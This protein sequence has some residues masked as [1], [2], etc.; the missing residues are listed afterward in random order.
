LKTIRIERI[1]LYYIVVFPVRLSTLSTVK[2]ISM[3]K[4]T[5]KSVS[6][7]QRIKVK[8]DARTTIMISRMSS[9]KIWK[10]RF[11]E[12]KIIA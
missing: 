5:Q 1:V 4:I 8:L 2:K 11:P 3:K 9:L 10:N 7:S 6:G 12:S